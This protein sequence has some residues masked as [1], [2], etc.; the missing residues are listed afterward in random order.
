MSNE[1]M[2]NEPM[3][4]EPMSDERLAEIRQRWQWRKKAKVTTVYGQSELF[5]KWVDHV[6]DDETDLLAEVE[7]LRHAIRSELN[8]RELAVNQIAE[9]QAEIAALIEDK[10]QLA[11]GFEAVNTQLRLKSS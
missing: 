4:D 7:R 9:Q 1:P 5:H 8:W 6:A 10:R 11:V 2:S 3:S